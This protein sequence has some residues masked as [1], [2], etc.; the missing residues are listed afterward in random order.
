MNPSVAGIVARKYQIEQERADTADRL[1]NANVG[2]LGA[3]T[4]AYPEEAASRAFATRAGGQTSLAQA[5]LFG[6]NAQL[7]PWLATSEANERNAAAQQSQ[8]QAG[9]TRYQTQFNPDVSQASTDRFYGPDAIGGSRG[10]AAPYQ[11]SAP[12]IINLGGQ[13]SVLDGAPPVT[14]I[15]ARGGQGGYLPNHYD[16]Q[17]RLMENS[18]TSKVPGKGD[19]KTD[20]QQAMLAP[21][22]AVLNRAAAEHL[23]RDT[24]SL[25]NAIGARRMGLTIGSD[26]DVSSPSTG[27]N[28]SPAI[29]N[30]TGAPKGYAGGTSDIPPEFRSMSPQGPTMNSATPQGPMRENYDKGWLEP[31][32]QGTTPRIPGYAE[33]TPRVRGAYPYN[34]PSHPMDESSATPQMSWPR[35]PADDPFDEGRTPHYAEGTSFASPYSLRPPIA[36]IPGP[37]TGSWDPNAAVP[38]RPFDPRA[39]TGIRGKPRA[40]NETTGAQPTQYLAKGTSKVGGKPAA[41]GKPAMSEHAKAHTPD[42]SAL[43]PGIMQALLAMSQGGGGMGGA[44]AGPAPQPGG[45][46]MPTGGAGGAPISLPPMGRRAA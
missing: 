17:G 12:G 5:Q 40:E 9:L 18:G 46:G 22:E 32:D 35:T 38:P 4:T 30:Q 23:G 1:A 16:S 34:T 42:G 39:A 13:H 21:G 25:L 43:S 37:N 28:G 14:G 26:A 2:Y 29:M 20:T 11:P 19:G 41:K 10:P 44:P 31:M 24:I 36:T 6:V 15:T 3:Q 7:A 27:S 33:G 8:A 45:M